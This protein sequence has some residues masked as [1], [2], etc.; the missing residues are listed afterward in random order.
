MHKSLGV[1]FLI[2]THS[3]DMVSAIKYI[4]EAE[5]CSDKLSYYC[6]SPSKMKGKYRFDSIGTDIEPIFYSFNKSYDA[7]ERYAG[8]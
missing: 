6:S 8:Q 4:S 2:S 3:T 1:S 7:L 5:S